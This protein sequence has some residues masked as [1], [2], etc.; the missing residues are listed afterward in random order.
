[1]FR[2]LPLF[3]LFSVTA[4]LLL[5]SSSHVNF[6]TWS[7]L[8]GKKHSIRGSTT[9]KIVDKGSNGRRESFRAVNATARDDRKNCSSSVVTRSPGSDTDS[10]NVA[11]VIYNSMKLSLASSQAVATANA[12][13]NVT[14]M[15]SSFF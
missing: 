15:D 5:P 14:G 12:S 2:S 6:N 1:M 13:A 8:E 3:F 9:V 7:V 4:T 10:A 11:R